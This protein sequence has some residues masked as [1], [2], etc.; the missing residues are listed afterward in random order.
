LYGGTWEYLREHLQEVCGYGGNVDSS[1][2]IGLTARA[3]A[4][5]CDVIEEIWR[6][7]DDDE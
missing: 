7:I 1:C 5:V 2:L 6:D 4:D 3:R